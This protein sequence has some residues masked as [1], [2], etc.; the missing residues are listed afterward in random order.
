MFSLGLASK[1]WDI[2]PWSITLLGDKTVPDGTLLTSSSIWKFLDRIAPTFDDT[3]RPSFTLVESFKMILLICSVSLILYFFCSTPSLFVCE[4]KG[5]KCAYL[6]SAD[7][8]LTLWSK[9]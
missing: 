5:T 8:E 2:F 9:K 3:T 4:A 6:E 7:D 1:F